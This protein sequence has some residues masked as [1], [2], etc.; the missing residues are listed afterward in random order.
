MSIEGRTSEP[1]SDRPHNPD[2][3]RVYK[4]PAEVREMIAELLEC[5]DTTASAVVAKWIEEGRDFT[6]AL[7]QLA[8]DTDIDDS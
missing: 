2:R 4:K 7:I 1:E 8:I 5:S 3:F 6:E